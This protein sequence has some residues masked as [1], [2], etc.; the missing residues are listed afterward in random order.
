MKNWLI[1]ILTTGI[2]FLLS[3]EERKTSFV[4]CSN[5]NNKTCIDWRGYDSYNNNILVKNWP[6][7]SI[8]LYKMMINYL[9]DNKT[10]LDTLPQKSNITTIFIYFFK[11]NRTTK[12]AISTKGDDYK[13]LENYL[14]GVTY[15]QTAACDKWTINVDRNLGYA[16]QLENPADYPACAKIKLDDQ[17]DTDFYEKHKHNE[18]VR[19]YHDLFGKSKK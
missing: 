8:D 12:N 9:H 17:C 2:F 7:D 5:P 1:I 18:I 14:G 13:F 6:R 10:I 19:Y 16:L 4:M 11:Y 15:S 3:C